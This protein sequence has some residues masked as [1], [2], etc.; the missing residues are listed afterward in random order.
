MILLL[1]VGFIIIL[2]GAI[3]WLFM[4]SFSQ[5][6]G[7][8]QWRVNTTDK[9]VALTFDDGPNEPYTSD[10]VDYLDNKGVKATFFQVGKCV[11]RYPETTKKMV[12]SGHVIGNHSLSHEFH[13]FFTEPGFD[14]QVSQNQ[15]IL[16]DTIGKTPA[17]FRSPWL[18]RQPRLLKTLRKYKLTP[19]SGEFC[20]SMEVFQIDGERIAK[21]A[22]RK[23]KPG[24][25]IIFHDGFDSRGGNRSQ[26]IK[27]AK[28]VVDHL[29]ENGY[30]MVTIDK[31]LG[32]E[33]YQ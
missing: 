13:K 16:T 23:V 15:K 14:D 19:V 2:S 28:I 29:L 1:I 12:R 6:F 21:A 24:A 32:V 31:L 8:Y 10:L 7:P 17:L 18:W 22:L 27:A 30:K 26:T 5:V 33:P 9:V 11:Q 4:S 25:I 20:H 3:Y